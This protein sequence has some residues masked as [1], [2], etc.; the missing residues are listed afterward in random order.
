[1]HFLRRLLIVSISCVFVTFHLYT[2]AF[3]SAAV[4]FQR[5]FHLALAST[6]GFLIYSF[7]GK[8]KS[9]S[10]LDLGLS[11]LSA[12]SLGYI[13]LS[14]S[15]IAVRIPMIT[16]LSGLD[17]F[18]AF[19]S[20]ILLLEL[21][22]RIAGLALVG[23]I[24][25]LLLYAYLGRYMPRLIAHPGFSFKD[26]LDFEF[27]SLEGV[28]SSPLGISSTYIVL[29]IILGV[30]LERSGTG[31]WFIELA[32]AISGKSRG[33][34]AKISCISSALFGSIS[35]SAAANVYATGTFTIPMMKKVGYSPD[36]AG[37][38]EAVASTGGQLM[39][40]VM[41]AAAFL[42]AELLGIPYLKVCKAA[43]IP[44]L[45]WYIALF[46]VL[47]FEAGKLNLKGLPKEEIPE[48]KGVL[49]RFYLIVPV[50]VLVFML[51]RG[52]SPSMSVFASIVVAFALML[53]SLRRELNV[54]L[55]LDIIVSSAE[56]SILIAV[57]CAGAGMVIGVI[58]QTGL[59]LSLTGIFTR[60]GGG[61]SILTLLTIA[62]SSII[63]GMGTPT[64]VAYV[65]VATL[66]VPALLKLGFDPLSS[67]MFVFYF[68]VLSMITPP[69]AIA[70]YAGAEIAGDAPM[71][72]GLRAV[73]IGFPIFVIPFMFM[74][75]RE[76]LLFGDW[77]SI[78]LKFFFAVVSVICYA[79]FYVGWFGEKLSFRLRLLFLVLFV[80]G[81]FPNLFI[82]FLSTS[83]VILLIFYLRSFS[84]IKKGV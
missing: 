41:G 71:R 67:H 54:K 13:A 50:F 11:A 79:L 32:S 21:I 17:L 51:V 25:V 55:L 29:F 45:L 34:P 56:R 6:L 37:A 38:V 40:P 30:L 62:I 36:F 23:V 66:G 82:S 75:N 22:R 76:L 58:T 27:Y 2:A 74:Y 14:S 61:Y 31:D 77:G 1:M 39:P 10:V 44:A 57:T 35:G 12:L 4:E 68:G 81:V 47:D 43:L 78:V 24:A 73:G 7:K 52:Y 33:G 9:S 83:L 26:I 80:F 15:R 69:V 20:L 64:T 5:S 28:L 42:M 72:T 3:G 53:F 48:L 8:S 59:G 18:F 70:A 19:V 49:K 60:L 46:F 65:I 16:P 84:K 63:M